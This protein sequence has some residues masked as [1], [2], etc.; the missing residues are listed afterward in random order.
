MTLKTTNGQD[1]KIVLKKFISG[2]Y[3]KSIFQKEVGEYLKS[4]YPN[5]IILEEIRIPKENF[6]FDFMVPNYNLVIECHGQQHT[7]YNK[8]FHNDIRDFNNQKERDKRK[9]LFCQI[10]KLTLIEIHIDEWYKANRRIR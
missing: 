4:Q 7:K 1:V 8:F 5:D 3:S 6:I 10:N 9:K 2:E